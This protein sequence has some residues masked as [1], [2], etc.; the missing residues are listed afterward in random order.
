MKDMR[1]SMESV[2]GIYRDRLSKETHSLIMAEALL[3]KQH[4]E[5]EALRVERDE[6]KKELEQELHCKHELEREVTQLK[7]QLEFYEEGAKK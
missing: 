1:V 3:N 7:G 4:D 5:I 6:L 2:M